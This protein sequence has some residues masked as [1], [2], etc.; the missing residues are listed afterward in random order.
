MDEIRITPAELND[1]R[2]DAVLEAGRAIARPVTVVPEDVP[3]P[4]YLLPPFYYG[5]ASCLAVLL[6]WAIGEP[7]YSDTKDQIPFVSDYLIF[8]PAA[9]AV[10]AAIGVVYGLVG[11][12]LQRALHCGAV[13]LGM[14]LLI[15]M[16]TTVMAD[17]AFGRYIAMAVAIT[18]RE[19]V[20]TQGLPF[21]GFSLF[22]L[23]C[24]RGLGWSLV[25]A[26]AGSA[27]GTAL[28]SKS[29]RFT[30]IIGGM[31]GGMLGGLLFDPI[32]MVFHTPGGSAAPSRAIGLLAIGGLLGVFV[33]VFESLSKEAWLLML[34]GPL[35]GKQLIL[36]KPLM[37]IGSAP[38]C[39]IYLFKDA[40]VAPHHATIE[41]RGSSFV[42]HDEGSANTVL[43]NGSRLTGD[44]V[45][46]D[47]DAI[48]VGST[49][50]KYHEREAS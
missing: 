15:T 33:G 24:G 21:R 17:I 49:V 23:M 41:R 6:G 28:K 3:T 50:L 10:G 44:H 48:T 4:F 38:K 25:G 29:L 26:G 37:T 27:L 43:V 39:D 5:L 14:G 46:T 8:G 31:V 7:F 40:A 36:F 45:L 42:L 47:E 35:K 12:N 20:H 30:G 18:G 9:A 34:G 22:L 32:S 2:I 11:R 1:P 16:A 19:N 13:G